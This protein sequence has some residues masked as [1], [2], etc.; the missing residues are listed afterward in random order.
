MSALVLSELNNQNPLLIL[1]MAN[2][3]N[4]SVDHGKRII[5]DLTEINGIRDFRVAIKFQYRDLPHFIHKD[6]RERRDLKYVDRFLS[7]KLSWPQFEELKNYISN[8][9]FL[10]ACTPFDEC[11]V[12]KIVE[13]GFDI[14][15]IASASFT[16]WSLLD[17]T[18]I[19]DGPIVASTAGANIQELDRVT[20]LFK[21]RRVDFAL[22]HCVASYPTENGDLLLNR[23]ATLRQRY[24]NVPIGY[25]T[26]ENPLNFLAG[27]LAL[28][29][30][31]VILE[32]H[33][34][35][36]ASGNT[37]N[38]YSSDG[39]TLARWLENLKSATSML[40]PSNPWNVVNES[41]QEALS[42]LRRFL[43]AKR[44]IKSGESISRSDFYFGIPGVP[45]QYQSKDAGKYD[46]L[47]ASA[48]IEADEAITSQNT[49]RVEREE[50]VFAIRDQ[51]VELVRRSG[52]VVPNNSIL[53]ISHHYGLDKFKEF[54]SC[55]ITVVNRDYCKKLIFLLP[56]QSHP[57]MFH[58]LKDET[59]FLLFGDLDLKLDNVQKQI[60]E[61]DTVAIAPS[62]VHEFITKGGA[63]IEEVSSSHMSDDSF[64]LDDTITKNLN[65]KTF[66][67][68]W[69]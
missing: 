53:E 57:P 28:A 24:Q 63:I 66:I 67:Q 39:E 22:M 47:I 68:Y 60:E 42:G 36:T 37:L 32:R 9:G 55:M 10:T 61:G 8:S 38:A 50:T 12:S 40:G 41:E 52:V 3:H 69:L 15:K 65:R 7:T 46:Q 16:D 14:L 33:V 49:N 11:S 56:G 31:A 26:H 23:I 30:G 54:G 21:N 17:S 58:K 45:N 5:D 25:S 29:A 20:T 34:G 48:N 13:H 44:R 19:W 4:G 18:S 43:F 1:D 2:N 64:Y 62:V 59:F 35:S 27:P 6:F 51:I